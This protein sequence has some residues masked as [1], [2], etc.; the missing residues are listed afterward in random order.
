MRRGGTVAQVKTNGQSVGR[1]LLDESSWGNRQQFLRAL[2]GFSNLSFLGSETDIQ[3]IKY[4]TMADDDL[5]EKQIVREMGMHVTRVND[6][7]I[8]TYVEA[9][10]SI[11]SLKLRDTY[12]FDG[13]N[14]YEPFL[15]SAKR[16]TQ[17]D[18]VARRAL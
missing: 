3:K 15:L 9:G 7:E 2:G 17:G 8:R 13:S 4:V 10:K 12:N 5:P 18:E 11:N 16:M 14:L 6:K 1:V